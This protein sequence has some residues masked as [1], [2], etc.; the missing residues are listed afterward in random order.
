MSQEKA[1]TRLPEWDGQEHLP[2]EDAV[3]AIP[4]Q[5][6]A[7][8]MS[9]DDHSA[10][11]AEGTAQPTRVATH[12]LGSEDDPGSAACHG[13]ECKASTVVGESRSGSSRRRL[14]DL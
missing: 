10:Y 8:L 2:L 9:Q 1:S 6:L 7:D 4:L 14:M 13:V 3:Q 5:V 12:T 11:L